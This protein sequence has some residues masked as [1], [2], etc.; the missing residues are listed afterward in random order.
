MG[1]LMDKQTNFGLEY[2]ILFIIENIQL[3]IVIIRINI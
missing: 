2:N 3:D 1:L